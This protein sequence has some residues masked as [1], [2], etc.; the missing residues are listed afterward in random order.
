L[1]PYTMLLTYFKP[2]RRNQ[3]LDDNVCGTIA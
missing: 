2:P 3:W 1:N